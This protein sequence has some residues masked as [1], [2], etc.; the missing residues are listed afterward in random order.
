MIQME[1]RPSGDSSRTSDYKKAVPRPPPAPQEKLTRKE[2]VALITGIKHCN[3]IADL[4]W[5]CHWNVTHPALFA[6]QT[7]MC[8]ADMAASEETL[9]RLGS[10]DLSWLALYL[11]LE[12]WLESNSCKKERVHFEELFFCKFQKVI[13]SW[14]LYSAS[15]MCRDIRV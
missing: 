4:N 15:C 2:Q 8:L 12:Y 7:G 14:Q 6:S 11:H 5:T 3:W 1:S 13:I 10:Q 9:Q